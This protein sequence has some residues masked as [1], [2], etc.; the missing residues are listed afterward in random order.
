[1]VTPKA[2]TSREMPKANSRTFDMYESWGTFNTRESS[3]V[4]SAGPNAEYPATI[5]KAATN[6]TPRGMCSTPWCP[7]VPLD[8]E[9]KILR[10]NAKAHRDNMKQ[11]IKGMKGEL[12]SISGAFK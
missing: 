9:S 5:H 10:W 2:V 3:G 1:V 11:N 12:I 6:H 7:S 8:M 4:K